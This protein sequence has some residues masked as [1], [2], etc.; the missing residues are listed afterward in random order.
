M[1]LLVLVPSNTAIRLAVTSFNTSELQSYVRM[2]LASGALS[3][4]C[5]RSVLKPPIFGPRGAPR[6]GGDTDQVQDVKCLVP[7]M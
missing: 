4:A 6:P 7:E 1:K 5:L 3:T 2:W